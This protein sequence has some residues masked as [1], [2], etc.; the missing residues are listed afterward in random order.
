MKILFYNWVDYLDAENR[1]GGVS[2]YQRNV[3]KALAQRPD[4][5]VSFLTSGLSH[6]LPARQPRWEALRHGRDRSR[7][8][9]FELVNSGVL[10]PAHHCFGD[11]AQT[12]HPATTDCFFDFIERTGPYDVIHFNNLEGLPVSALSLKQRWPQTKVVFSLHNYYPFCPQ[13]NFWFQE[14]ETCDDF[15]GGAKCS[16]CLTGGHNPHHIKL[17]NGLAYR[18]KRSGLEPGSRRFHYSFVWTMR[19]GRRAVGLQR[20]LK[21]LFRG[22]DN[23]MPGNG[24]APK[25]ATKRFANRR[26]VMVKTINENCDL[27]LCVSDAVRQIAVQYG[28]RPDLCA[29]SYIGTQQAEAYTRTEPRQSILREDGTVSLGF[30]GY[31]RRDKG[32]MFLLEALETL[33]AELAKRVRFTAAARKG[34]ETTMARLKALQGQLA[35]VTHVDGYSH[36]DL[37]A[38]LA[39][40]D[41]GVVPVL[42]HDNLPQV[43]IELHSRHIPLLT[44][45]MGGAQELGNCPEMVFRAGDVAAFHARIAAILNGEVD[46][47]AYW[48]SARAPT[49]MDSHINELLAHYSGETESPSASSSHG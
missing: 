13:V 35:E 18:L 44:A 22:K 45:D 26:D 8:N 46:M 11:P 29:T 7:Q 4:V 30:L 41:V 47:D 19:I 42:W 14:K 31:M 25:V 20:R 48:Q 27:V 10:A 15:D 12:D 38:L 9:H 34:D 32:F 33:P 39:G 1:G 36:D 3:M 21:A 43:A 2:I 37:E 23:A 40:I 6:D 16:N 28:L 17:A 49:T 5:D 24:S